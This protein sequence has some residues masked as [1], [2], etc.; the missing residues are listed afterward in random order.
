MPHSRNHRT[1]SLKYSL[2]VVTTVAWVCAPP[3]TAACSNT[4]ATAVL[5]RYQITSDRWDPILHQHWISVTD[6]DHPEQPI[7]SRITNSASDLT[8]A[9]QNN[10]K[11]S[12][13]T[14]GPLLVRAGENITVLRR[15]ASL[16]IEIRG[17][18]EQSAALGKQ[19]RV[20]LSKVGVDIEQAQKEIVGVVS[21]PATVEM[22]P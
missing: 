3:V 12:P 22:Q 5:L 8:P 14:S 20:R 2:T 7:L 1:R 18:A 4:S 21:G 19:V 15:E 11:N 13:T 10:L 9:S 17:V 6:C 16:Q